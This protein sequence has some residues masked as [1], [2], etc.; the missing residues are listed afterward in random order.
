MLRHVPGVEMCLS[1]CQLLFDTENESPGSRP[2]LMLLWPLGSTRSCVEKH[3]FWVRVNLVRQ[4][5]AI[6]S[7]TGGE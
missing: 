7:S 6:E 2:G 1:T 3:L 5:S 4:K